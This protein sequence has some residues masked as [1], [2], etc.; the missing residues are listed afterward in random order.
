M[1][2][3]L[4]LIILIIFVIKLFIIKYDFNDYFNI[5]ISCLFLLF[6]Y[7]Y[8]MNKNIYFLII[9]LLLSIS[10]IVYSIFKSN[11]SDSSIIFINGNINFKNRSCIN[12]IR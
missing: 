5:T 2:I 10:L 9:V 8:I 1:I 12:G 4:F 7:L 6:S 11:S 3:K